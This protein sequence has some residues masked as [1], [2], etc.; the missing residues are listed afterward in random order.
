MEV[1]FM[2]CKRTKRFLCVELFWEVKLEISGF[3][4]K[5]TKHKR[6]RLI[7]FTVLLCFLFSVQSFSVKF[8][9]NI[10]WYNFWILKIWNG[11]IGQNI[12]KFFLRVDSVTIFDLWK[13]PT[14]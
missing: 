2:L 7:N 8:Y 11:I 13:P 6:F 12:L 10:F 1:I 9:Y 4:N 5:K 14:P 3:E